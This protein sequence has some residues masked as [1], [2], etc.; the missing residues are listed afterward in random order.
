MAKNKDKSTTGLITKSES[1]LRRRNGKAYKKLKI[2]TPKPRKG[3]GGYSFKSIAR[4][5]K[6]RG[7]NAH[8]MVQMIREQ[9]QVEKDSRGSRPNK[10]RP[11]TPVNKMDRAQPAL[12]KI[13][14]RRLAEIPA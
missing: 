13:K 11:A 7:I 2:S 5:A 6:A 1:V 4:K 12:D 9:L 3:V 10:P 8:V 14:R